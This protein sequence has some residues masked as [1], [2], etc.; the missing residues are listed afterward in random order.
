MI[1]VVYIA[2]TET[3][4]KFKKSGFCWSNVNIKSEWVVSKMKYFCETNGW[5]KSFIR[6]GFDMQGSNHNNAIIS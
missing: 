4:N 5:C 1:N 3:G 6:G 2:P